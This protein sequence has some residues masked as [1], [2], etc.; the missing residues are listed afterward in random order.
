MLFK[1]RL[2]A[3]PTVDSQS[4]VMAGVIDTKDVP[5]SDGMAL[6]SVQLLELDGIADTLVSLSD[7]T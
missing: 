5:S 2:R 1:S 4:Q 6:P 3:L 7:S